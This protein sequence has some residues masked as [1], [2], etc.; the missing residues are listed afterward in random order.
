MRP[1]CP[2]RPRPGRPSA[3]RE[4]SVRP[5]LEHEVQPEPVEER[6]VVAHDEHGAAIGRRAPRPADRR[7][8]GRGCSS[9]RRA[10][11]AAAAG[12]PGAAARARRGTARRPRASR[13][14][15]SRRRHGSGTARAGCAAPTVG[16]RRGRRDDVARHRVAVIEPVDAL[17]QV[18]DAVGVRLGVV[19]NPAS[20]PDRPATPPLEQRRLADP[21]GPMRATRSGPWTIHD[22]CGVPDRRDPATRRGRRDRAASMRTRVVVAHPA[23]GGIRAPPG[24]MPRGRPSRCGASPPR[25]RPRA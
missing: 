21:L 3:F 23:L 19:Q 25:P 5:E 15:G 22:R 24:R 18:A 11:A 6:V 14:A 1:S 2:D 16:L 10:P 9:A 8:R 17:R 13:P 7:C 20:A 12:R 4:R